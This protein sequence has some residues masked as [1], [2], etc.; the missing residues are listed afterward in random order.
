M[1]FILTPGIFCDAAD[2]VSDGA[3]KIT[4]FS[5]FFTN[6]SASILVT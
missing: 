2:A 6:F 4:L 3:T 1:I 5:L